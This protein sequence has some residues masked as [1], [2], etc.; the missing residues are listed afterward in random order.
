MFS[1]FF[2]SAT[3][4]K[5]FYFLNTSHESR[6]QRLQDGL[7]DGGTMNLEPINHSLDIDVRFSAVSD[8]HPFYLSGGRRTA[9]L[10]TAT[11]DRSA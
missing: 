8:L 2:F 1:P 5:V 4:H 10:Y 7:V 9:R 3:T 6:E 11:D